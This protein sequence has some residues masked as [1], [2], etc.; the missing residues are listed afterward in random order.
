[1]S[2]HVNAVRLTKTGTY[3]RVIVA[4]DG[5]VNDLL[6]IPAA[7]APP[8]VGEDVKDV[9]VRP[10]VETNRDGRPMRSIVYWLD[11]PE[12]RAAQP[13]NGTPAADD[14]EAA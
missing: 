1:M 11:T 5:R 7:V 10:Q 3:N 14:G 4:G 8:K 13:R 2:G 9:P 12:A 6:M